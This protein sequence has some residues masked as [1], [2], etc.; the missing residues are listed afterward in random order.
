L[1]GTHRPLSGKYRLVTFGLGLALLFSAYLGWCGQAMGASQHLFN[2]S[3]S[4]VGGTATSALDPIP[5]PGPAHPPQPFNNAC[6][7]TT[8]ALG[9][10]YVAS[11]G[12]PS[13]EERGGRIDIFDSTGH[14]L[15]EIVN[16]FGPCRPAVDSEG[17]IF[18]QEVTSTVNHTPRT[19][20]Y[21]PSE[22]PP[23]PATT[24]AGPRTVST[25]QS[26]G[27]AVDPSNDHVFIAG[28]N[29]DE[30]EPL[31]S[32]FG[33]IEEMSP[34]GFNDAIGAEFGG[35]IAVCA[36]SADLYVSAGNAVNV[37]SLSG[38]HELLR[39]ITGAA[40][41]DG[42]LFQ[43]GVPRNFAIDQD[44][45]DIYAD[46]VSR[47]SHSV[48]ELTSTGEFVGEITHSLAEASEGSGVAVD[49]SPG[50]PN[51]GYLFVTSGQAANAHLYAFEPPAATQPPEVTGERVEAVTA[52]SATLST[53]V[54]AKG[55]STTVWFEVGTGDCATGP[56][57]KVPADGIRA[58]EEGFFTE[59]DTAVNGLA[60]AT[61][62]HF[63][64]LAVSAN[65]EA[66]GPDQT[67][68]TYPAEV[69]G[70]PDGRNYELVTPPD[71][72]GHIPTAAGGLS[73]NE[74][75]MFD[76]DLST[77]D[78]SGLLFYSS[79]GALPGLPGNGVSDSYEATRTES[80]WV[81]EPTGPT[82]SQSVLPK[83]GGVAAGHHY[84]FWGIAS[85]GGSLDLGFATTHY[86]RTPTGS[87]EL[88]GQGSRGSAP[89]VVGQ[90]ISGDGR[91][92]I[93]ET[94]NGEA[95]QAPML[96]PNAPPEGTGAVYER[97]PG[98]PTS[99]VSLLPGDATPAAGE[100]AK[101]VGASLDGSSVAFAIGGQLYVRVDGEKTMQLGSVGVT[102]GGL[103]D[104]GEK[105]VYVA[106][107]DI[108]VANV[109][110]GA[111]ERLTIEGHATLVN[112]SGDGS[113]VYFE[114]ARKLASGGVLGARNLYVASAGSIRFVADLAA[115]DLTGSTAL[116]GWT[117]SDAATGWRKGPA[118]H[119]E[120]G[121]DPSRTTP[122]GNV[123]VFQSFADL[124]GYEANGHSEI[125]RFDAGT[126]GLTCV[127]CNPTGV[128]A[129]GDAKLESL[130][131][132]T[133]EPFAPVMA[134]DD[135]SNVTSD[136]NT[137][138]FQSP[139][140]LVPA[141]TDGTVDVYEWHNGQLSLISSGKS[142]EASYLYA[143]S[144]D[145]SNVFFQTADSLVHQDQDG[146]VASIYDARIGAPFDEAPRPS[147]P[148]FENCQGVSGSPAW[149]PPA[150]TALQSPGH[151]HTTVK[152]TCPKG[153]H[154]AR[155][156]GKLVCV[157]RKKRHSV[158]RQHRHRHHK[159][160]RRLRGR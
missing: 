152:K 89:V 154:V 34:E 81:T 79:T 43:N 11:A 31:S 27:V 102:Y 71:T 108:F 50:S 100:I 110:T 111:T 64:V 66:K 40:A 129:T 148:C 61:T 57:E 96:E 80:G 121:R 123:L 76:T 67:F 143:M 73:L 47:P 98:G 69:G 13:G 62:Y 124:T 72:N 37:Y 116:T 120:A 138:F 107:G 105:A 55:S 21:E 160:G 139:D 104:D 75:D 157:K 36:E 32:G 53:Q 126:G 113:H 39:R 140:R 26:D 112:V 7:V 46:N 146:G 132:A 12:L 19:V 29:I 48:V 10:I 5:D 134:F 3:L 41:P 86:L 28:A 153:Q 6:G 74:G 14:F 16:Q 150:S 106:E 114:S 122:N 84:A 38:S 85:F 135:I 97:I 42:V 145:G 133:T 127:S 151:S 95:G 30:F 155:R 24:Y 9:N 63:R 18:V 20:V 58:G 109:V 125:Y 101:Y 23:T 49:S 83:S 44:G 90:W 142:A 94:E 35:G 82:S 93:F 22:Y 1:Q 156:K 51:Q 45:C 103:S 91:H 130:W 15:T 77:S 144:A 147:V 52:E 136:G 159:H 119:Y 59:V 54:N 115:E 128:A 4:L 118:A 2:P 70:L 141:D 17:N 131:N 92:V 158:G 87:F 88:I 78:G 8:D 137:V 149:V 60:P 117:E 65:G 99:V 25:E 33:L 68:E 56:C